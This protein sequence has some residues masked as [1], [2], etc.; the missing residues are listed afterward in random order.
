MKA[1][2]EVLDPIVTD[3]AL[4]LASSVDLPTWLSV[5]IAVTFVPTGETSSLECALTCASGKVIEGW[6]PNNEV[7]DHLYELTRRHWQSTQDLGQPRWYKMIVTVE[8]SG[9][10]N[11]EFEYKDDYQEGDI[12]KCG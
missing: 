7:L 2:V 1:L 5:Q 8:R 10:F 3:T 4:C 11:V 12:M 6:Y 9:K